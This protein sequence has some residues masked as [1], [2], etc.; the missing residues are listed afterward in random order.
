MKVL[1]AVS[2]ADGGLSSNVG[3]LRISTLKPGVELNCLSQHVTT[4]YN[5]IIYNF[6]LAQKQ[7]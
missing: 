3:R 1:F 4:I 5:Y 6:K 7:G 2:V